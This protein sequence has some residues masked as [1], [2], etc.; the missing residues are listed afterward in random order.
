MDRLVVDTLS[1]GLPRFP[2]VQPRLWGV[3]GYTSWQA[4]GGCAVSE[5]GLGLFQLTLSARKGQPH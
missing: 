3:G 2:C 1:W 5:P 4:R